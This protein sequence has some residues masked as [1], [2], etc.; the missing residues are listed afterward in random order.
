MPKF[1]FSSDSVRYEVYTEIMTAKPTSLPAIRTAMRMSRRT[2][3]P[4]KGHVEVKSE[5]QVCA[6]ETSPV[7]TVE[8]IRSLERKPTIQ[9]K[10]PMS[11]STFPSA[12]VNSPYLSP[13]AERRPHWSKFHQQHPE[14]LYMDWEKDECRVDHLTSLSPKND[15]YGRTKC[16]WNGGKAILFRPKPRKGTDVHTTT[17]RPIQVTN[18]RTYTRRVN[19]YVGNTVNHSVEDRKEEKEPVKDVEIYPTLKLTTIDS[20]ELNNSSDD[21]PLSPYLRQKRQSKVNLHSKTYLSPTEPRFT[22]KYSD[23]T[24][25]VLGDTSSIVRRRSQRMVIAARLLKNIN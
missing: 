11:T 20:N 1:P 16:N 3:K 13:V 17:T 7:H 10:N 19:T 2:V 4:D 22:R 23:E 5:L 6:E 18:R 9:H 21:S 24:A 8:T 15:L 25:H 14:K 12:L